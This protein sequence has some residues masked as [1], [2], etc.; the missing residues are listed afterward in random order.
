MNENT[1][2]FEKNLTVVG[3]AVQEF[4]D[5]KATLEMVR[6]ELAKV[7]INGPDDKDGYA[8]AKDAAKKAGELRRKIE[9]RKKELKEE[10]LRASQAYDKVARDLQGVINP[11]EDELKRQ[12]ADVDA[13][14]ERE[15]MKAAR[16]AELPVRKAKL[17]QYEHSYTDEQILL[18]GDVEFLKI[19]GEFQ[20]AEIERQN[21]VIRDQQ[22]R[23]RAED[24]EKQK[25]REIAEAAEKARRDAEAKAESDRIAEQ[26]RVRLAADAERR[27]K[28]LPARKKMMADLMKIIPDMSDAMIDAELR[29]FEAQILS[30]D[31]AGFAVMLDGMK[32]HCARQRDAV[33]RDMDE[34]GKVSVWVNAMLAVARPQLVEGS[35]MIG[36]VEKIVR[37]LEENQ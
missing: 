33:L 17:D 14:H 26:E 15:K 3:K 35:I 9:A 4:G 36:R 37:Y 6:E 27:E 21:A 7:K 13:H 12:I 24:A 5:V 2:E 18:M 29:R 32:E 23:Q 22:E 20:Q 34:A 30:E 8:A 10:S 31:E 19:L 28:I 1:A 25:Q 16:A 11:I